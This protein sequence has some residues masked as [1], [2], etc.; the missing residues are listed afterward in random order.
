VSVLSEL[1][2]AAG[3]TAD[4]RVTSFERK[5]IGAIVVAAALGALLGAYFGGRLRK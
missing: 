5:V 3:Q 2:R 4:Q 1:V